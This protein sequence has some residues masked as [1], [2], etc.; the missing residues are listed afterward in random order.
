MSIA[1]DLSSLLWT[2]ELLLSVRFALSF[3]V[4]TYVTIRKKKIQTY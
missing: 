1:A 2:S 3:H 4:V